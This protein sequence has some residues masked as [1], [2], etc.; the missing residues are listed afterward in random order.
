MED[1]FRSAVPFLD[2][3][4]SLKHGRRRE[5][6]PW[7]GKN[8]KPAV[9]SHSGLSSNRQKSIYSLRRRYRLSDGVIFTMW[10]VLVLESIVATTF[11]FCPSYCLALSWSSN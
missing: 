7:G 8:E 5:A 10:R 11:T 6:W 1:D 9:G 2:R 3:T 4:L